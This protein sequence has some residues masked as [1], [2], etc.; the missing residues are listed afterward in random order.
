MHWLFL[1]LA[2]LAFVF[3]L[4]GALSVWAAVLALALKVALAGLAVFPAY[5]IWQFIF[6]RKA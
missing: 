4:L 1:I 5:S 2:A 6:R 3:V